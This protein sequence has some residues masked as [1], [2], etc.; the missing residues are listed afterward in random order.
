MIGMGTPISQSRTERMLLP[1]SLFVQ[2]NFRGS[3][4][5]QRR[6]ERRLHGPAAG[7][8]AYGRAAQRHIRTR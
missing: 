1:L 3:R 6:H 4:W 5:F 7:A 8:F 2:H